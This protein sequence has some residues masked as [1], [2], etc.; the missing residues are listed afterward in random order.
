MIT[1]ATII[2]VKKM[3]VELVKTTLKG[4]SIATKPKITKAI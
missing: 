4:F 3:N 2:N 1:I